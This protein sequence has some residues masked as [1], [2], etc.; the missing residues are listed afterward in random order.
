[1][2]T[3]SSL[4]FDRAAEGDFLYPHD[5]E[6]YVIVVPTKL[7][8]NLTL[9]DYILKSPLLNVW[10]LAILL[11]TINRKFL[12][13]FTNASKQL[14][15]SDITIET[16][17]LSFGSTAGRQIANRPERIAILFL[18][19]FSILANILCSSLLFQQLSFVSY[20]PNILKLCDINKSKHLNVYYPAIFRASMG[21]EMELTFIIF[22]VIFQKYYNKFYFRINNKLINDTLPRIYN[23]MF[24]KNT[25]NVYILPKDGV[26]IVL[27]YLA[28][29]GSPNL[30]HKIE[31]GFG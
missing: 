1:M 2:R 28:E 26:N 14:R 5:V 21:L 6:E 22:K 15:W 9:L 31:H 23:L 24:T 27:S 11:F 12:Q 16:I 4:S 30:F 29:N 25:K 17:G 7:D 8:S 19:V 13:Y 10:A 20:K 3:Q 18:S